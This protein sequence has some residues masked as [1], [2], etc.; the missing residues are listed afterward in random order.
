MN[1]FE[2]FD[3]YAPKNGPYIKEHSTN[4]SITILFMSQAT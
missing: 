4:V 1:C 3:Q 2:A